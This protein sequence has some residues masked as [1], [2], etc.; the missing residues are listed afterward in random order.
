MITRQLEEALHTASQDPA[1][2]TNI[3]S[4]YNEAG[5]QHPKDSIFRFL[6]RVN[7]GEALTDEILT[8]LALSIKT[9]GFGRDLFDFMSAS[10]SED[11]REQAWSYEPQEE[12]FQPFQYGLVKYMEPCQFSALE[13]GLEWFDRNWYKACQGS[14]VMYYRSQDHIAFDQKNFF[15]HEEGKLHPV[16]KVNRQGVERTEWESVARVWVT[17]TTEVYKESVFN[18]SL[19]AG[20]N[21]ETSIVNRWLGWNHQ[22]GAYHK[23][24]EVFLD[25]VK[26]GLSDNR[27]NVYNYI[28]DWLA[29]LAQKPHELPG[30]ALVLYGTQGTG[31]GLFAEA[32]SM[33]CEGYTSAVH[34]KQQILGNY[35]ETLKDKLFLFLDEAIFHGDLASTDRF[36]PLITDGALPINPKYGHPELVTNHCRYIITTNNDVPMNIKSD[37]RRFLIV[38]PSSARKIIPGSTEEQEKR[39]YWKNVYDSIHHP[40]FIPALM[41]YLRERE[42]T[43]DI[44]TPPVTEEK[45]HVVEYSYSSDMAFFFDLVHD[46]YF[47]IDGIINS[48]E[49]EEVFKN[50]LWEGY[51][52][53]V[54][55]SKA[56]RPIGKILF[57]KSLFKTFPNSVSVTRHHG[58]P[59]AF[60][61]NVTKM[62]ADFN[63]VGRIK[64]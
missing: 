38:K 55:Q 51:L 16:I 22:P 24:L 46:K 43:V 52:E 57:Y 18:P 34:D 8:R 6:G 59:E 39:S 42:I 23:S 2:L 63:A 17:T 12:A 3:P 13:V 60:V 26:S 50:K 9:K 33:L 29:H 44:K 11:R 32:V 64:V 7:L 28:L 25:L 27:P 30:V 10:V 62:E 1:N 37:D 40:K 21:K 31:K 35:N 54:N 15:Q 49:D 56:G 19:D 53:S 14:K 41:S 45:Q 20:R 61:F 36:K 47:T 4:F 48:I 58:Q 5:E